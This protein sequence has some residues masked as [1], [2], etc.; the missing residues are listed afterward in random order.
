MYTMEDKLAGI[1]L[2]I[3]SELANIDTKPY[4]DTIITLLLEDTKNVFGKSTKDGLIKEFKLE[5]Y[6]WRKEDE[7]IIRHKES[8]EMENISPLS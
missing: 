6:G 8:K 3:Q 4:S 2:K 7:K 5:K 1:K